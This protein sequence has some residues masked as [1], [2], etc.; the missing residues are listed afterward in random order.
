[1]FEQAW[2]NGAAVRLLGVGASGLGAPPRQLSLWDVAPADSE[3]QRRVQAAL[4]ALRNR[5]GAQVVRRAS[6]LQDE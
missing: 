3:Q 2:R 6:D 1:L 5:F 4:A